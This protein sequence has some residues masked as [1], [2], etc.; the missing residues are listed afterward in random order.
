MERY[1]SFLLDGYTIKDIDVMTDTIYG[2]MRAV[3][4]LY[5]DKR[6]NEP[7][8]RS[9]QSRAAILLREQKKYEDE[10]DRRQPLHDK[11][12]CMMKIIADGSDKL[13]LE[14]A[15]WK[16]TAL[17]RLAGFR[18]QEYLMNKKNEIRYYV[19]PNDEKIV[20]AFTVKNFRF[21]DRDGIRLISSV[22][23]SNR[24]SVN[25]VGTEYDIQKNRCNGQEVTYTRQDRFSDFCPVEISLDIVDS[26]KKLGYTNELDPLC[27][28]RKNGE[29]YYLTDDLVT[30]YYR[31]VTKMVFPSISRDE[32]MLISTHSLRVKA[33]VLLQEAGK[34]GT[35]I[36][37]RLRWLSNCFEI[38]LRN[39]DVI[40]D[41]HN[42]ALSRV[43]EIM[44]NRIVH[45]IAI[46]SDNL[47]DIT[48]DTMTIVDA[49]ANEL[50]DED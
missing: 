19:K 24:N 23:L 27:V 14:N 5:K 13:G 48:N 33:A 46:S 35:Y 41:Q 15:I 34:D 9:S 22:A 25:K 37:L 18:C 11:V 47:P 30:E 29:V 43:N 40:C 21:Y 36:K 42:S 8:D 50:D 31:K 28:Y 3:N 20:R 4:K 26:A 17:G 10:P 16:W 38:Y 39:T 45:G 12:I 1:V 49:S 6:F 7:F 32:L 44:Y 2:Y